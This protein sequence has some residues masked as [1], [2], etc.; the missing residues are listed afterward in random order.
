MIWFSIQVGDVIDNSKDVFFHFL[1][2][3]IRFAMFLSV[4]SRLF[5]ISGPR[6]CIYVMPV[7]V[8]DL[9]M[10]I[11]LV[12]MPVLLS[13]VCRCINDS[14]PA[15]IYGWVNMRHIDI[16]VK[17]YTLVIW[18]LY[19]HAYLYLLCHS[20]Q[21][22]VVSVLFVSEVCWFKLHLLEH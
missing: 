6:I 14:H 20:L 7:S 9:L 15:W 18:E 19:G 2:K 4:L 10:L 17:H 22:V 11:C 5:Q 16:F 21:R 8:H 13:L 1:L 12:W 3:V